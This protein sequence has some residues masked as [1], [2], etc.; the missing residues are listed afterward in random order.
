MI[1]NFIDVMKYLFLFTIAAL[2]SC[3]AKPVKAPDPAPANPGRQQADS[4]DTVLVRIVGSI[5]GGDPDSCILVSR[6]LE[7]DSGYNKLL[8]KYICNNLYS[9]DPDAKQ[10]ELVTITNRPS[11]AR[12]IMLFFDEKSGYDKIAYYGEK[13]RIPEMRENLLF[14]VADCCAL[15]LHPIA[16]ALLK[17]DIFEGVE[18]LWS[19]ADCKKLPSLQGYMSRV[20]T[21]NFFACADLV[22]FFHNVGEYGLRDSFLKKAGRTSGFEKNVATLKKLIAENKKFDI[23]TFRESTYGGM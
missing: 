9:N 21:T 1:I 2:M 5:T 3:H 15:Q 11:F 14:G 16:D 19:K 13:N 6:R 12:M 4:T 22:G 17:R 10:A 18:V 20:D 8:A 7:P 23:S